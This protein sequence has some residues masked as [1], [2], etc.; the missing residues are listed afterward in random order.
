MIDKEIIQAVYVQ[1]K[2]SDISKLKPIEEELKLL[3]IKY[4]KEDILVSCMLTKNSKSL[5]TALEDLENLDKKSYEALLNKAKVDLEDIKK[6]KAKKAKEKKEKEKLHEERKKEIEEFAEASNIYNQIYDYKVVGG[7]TKTAL[8]NEVRSAMS[9]GW[10]PLGGVSAA[11]F[12]MTPVG[13][14]QYIQALVKYR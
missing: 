6:E 1:L 13:G 14:N 2:K 7:K 8:I 5:K 4:T 3:G 10:K 11:A 9:D 12:G